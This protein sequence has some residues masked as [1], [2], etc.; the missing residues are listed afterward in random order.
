[1]NEGADTDTHISN[2]VN[3]MCEHCA[4]DGRYAQRE[5][6]RQ[7][8]SATNVPRVVNR[9]YIYVSCRVWRIPERRQGL[10]QLPPYPG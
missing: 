7:P 2:K 4:Y 5:R 10:F 6:E 8:I 3:M 1:M 9:M